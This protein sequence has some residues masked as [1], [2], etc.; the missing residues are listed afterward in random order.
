MGLLAR[1]NLTRH[2]LLGEFLVLLIGMLFAGAWLSRGVEQRLI[3]HEGE[4]FALYVDSV[5]SE[6][7]QSIA[8]GGWLDE[9]DI[10]A[11]D[12]LL[13]QTGLGN[14]LVAFA[15]WSRDGRVLYSN[16]LTTIGTRPAMVPALAAA[17]DGATQSRSYQSGDAK[18]RGEGA[19]GSTVIETF[20]PVR[21]ARTHS[22]LAV[23][24]ISQT[25]EVLDQTI[26]AAQQRSWTVVIVVTTVMYLLLAALIRHASR[27]MLTQ[28]QQSQKRISE[29]T[30]KLAQ[31]EEQQRRVAR[32]A[33]GATARGERFLH[34][35]AVDMHDGP[36]QELVLAM[37]RLGQLAEV[38][39]TCSTPVG[40]TGDTVAGQIKTVQQ[41]LNATL[42]DMRSISKGLHLP[43]IEELS[44]ADIASRVVRNYE[45]TS[46]VKVQMSA[47]NLPEDASLPVKITVFR[48]LQESLANGFRHGGA[49]NQCVLL[50]SSDQRVQVEVRD[51]GKGFDPRGASG[52]DHL[53]LEGMR[54]RVEMLGGTFSVWSAP[55]QGTIVRAD[56]PLSRALSVDE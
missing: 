30:I 1:V 51:E 34:R 2:M 28:E 35:V 49:A 6:N 8:N 10:V 21:D 42:A 33:E 47:S 52:E 29:L 7:V 43:H 25:N 53:G 26:K 22:I 41:G 18:R 37:M 31:N 32:A 48:L 54:E 3:D 38:C 13:H 50:N 36:G 15:L 24:Q 27:S 44:L 46:G 56:L 45:R 40:S 16:D 5:L 11:V 19:G 55:G 9:L 17:A 20:A 39:G 23:S 4:L 14:R 12:K